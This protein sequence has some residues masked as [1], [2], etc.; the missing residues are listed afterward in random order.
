MN[1][2]DFFHKNA[3]STWNKEKKVCTARSFTSEFGNERSIT[4]YID[5]IIA[6]FFVVVRIHEPILL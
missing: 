5:V 2:S 6:S 4:L 1:I 3:V